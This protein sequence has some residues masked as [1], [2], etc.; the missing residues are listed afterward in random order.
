MDDGVEYQ[1][2]NHGFTAFL[3]LVDVL[4]NFVFTRPLKG[5]S[6]EEVTNAF[7]DVVMQ[8]GRNPIL[9]TVDAGNVQ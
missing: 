8:T 7:Q 5:K 9:L 4:S 6:T 2:V 3:L 1:D